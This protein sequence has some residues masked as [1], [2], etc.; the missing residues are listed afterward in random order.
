[1]GVGKIMCYILQTLAEEGLESLCVIRCID[2]A[3]TEMQH[4]ALTNTPPRNKIDERGNSNSV[5]RAILVAAWART[6][7]PPGAVW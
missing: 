2:W 6:S 1:M 4:K 7:T 3:T 5:F